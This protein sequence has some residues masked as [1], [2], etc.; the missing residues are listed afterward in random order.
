MVARG[1]LGIE[2]PIE[3]IPN[4]QKRLLKIAGTTPS[5]RSPPRRCWRRWSARHARRAPRRRTSR[6]RSTTGPTPSCSQ[7]R[8]RS[9]QHPVKAVQMMARIAEETERELPYG[10][11]LGAAHGVSATW[12]TRSPTTPSC[13]PTSSASPR[14]WC[15][16]A[17]GGRH[18][19]CRRT[20]RASRFWP[21]AE[22]RDRQAAEPA[23]R[24]PCPP[25]TRR[26][27]TWTSCWRSCADQAKGEGL[28][29]RAT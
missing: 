5:P 23:V 29:S 17:R 27:T 24:D 21:V 20:G 25:T 19:W 2:L 15:R 16:R 12:P 22:R 26:R 4:V 18:G 8:R 7:R 11:W 3:M 13:P 14:S 9:A 10:D 28:R 6:T 1:D